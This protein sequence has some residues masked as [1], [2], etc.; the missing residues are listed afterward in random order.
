MLDM[1]EAFDLVDHR[2]LLSR[3]ASIGISKQAL[4]WLQTYISSR[5]QFVHC[6]GSSAVFSLPACGVPQGSV[7]GPLLFTIYLLGI[8][9]IIA[10]HGI[11]YLLYADDIQL[12]ASSPP[13][14][15][16]LLITRLEACLREVSD[17]LSGSFLILNPTKTDVMVIGSG[18]RLKKTP[19]GISDDQRCQSDIQEP[20]QKSGRPT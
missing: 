4:S 13:Q 1:S 17:W 16:H 20:S 8:G 11:S 5:T 10:K 18:P 19:R 7:L 2:L 6:S 9:S 12:F 3:L 14:H 15:L